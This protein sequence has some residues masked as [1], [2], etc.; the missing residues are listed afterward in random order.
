MSKKEAFRKHYALWNWLAENPTKSKEEWPGWMNEWKPVRRRGRYRFY[1][2]RQ[3]FLCEY[4]YQ[5]RLKKSVKVST[6]GHYYSS[7]CIECIACVLCVFMGSNCFSPTNVYH[8]W[9]NAT[10]I[11]ERIKY[12]CSIRDVVKTKEVK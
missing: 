7:K 6:A 8:K 11:K 10:D 3:C 4:Y 5:S 12:A 9:Q 1:P 2:R